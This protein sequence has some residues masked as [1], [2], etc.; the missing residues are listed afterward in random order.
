MKKLFNV[1]VLTLAINFLA[2]AGGL[3]WLASSGKLNKAKFAAIRE[4][5]FP[6]TTTQP[7]DVKKAEVD[8]TTQPTLKLELLLAKNSGLP[9]GQRIEAL[10]RTFDQ[11]QAILDRRE[12]EMMAIKEQADKA[13]KGVREDRDALEKAAKAFKVRE[14]ESKKLATDEGFQNTLSLYNSMN[15]KQVKQVFATLDDQ[16][17]MHYLQAMEPRAASKIIKEFKT[18]DEVHRIQQVMEQMRLAKLAT[19]QPSTPQASVKVP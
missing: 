9:A 7:V 11:Q 6:P 2:I 13:A 16:T 8:P 19:T 10:Q 14:A 18:D 5:V 12:R 3:G 15:S 4:V 1:L 17:V